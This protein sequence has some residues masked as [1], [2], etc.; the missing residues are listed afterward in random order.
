MLA[1]LRSQPLVYEREIQYAEPTETSSGD[2]F[3]WQLEF[4]RSP[5]LFKGFSGPVGSGKSRALCYEALKLSYQN[6]GCTGV[7]G[8]PTYPMLRDSTL[9]TFR[10]LLDINQVPYRFHKS[11]YALELLEPRSQILFRSLENY[12]RIRGTNLAWFGIDELTY[13]K[14]E[15]WL[16]LEA[17]LRDPR[18]NTAADSHP[19]HRRAL[20]GSG[21]IHWAGQESA[22]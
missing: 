4:H 8:A 3:E 18:P 7:I 5:S 19:G 9:K 16:R 1:P 2:A 21:T 13:C 17:R 6:R 20:I 14:L 22:L 11:E 10:E 15:A 12:E